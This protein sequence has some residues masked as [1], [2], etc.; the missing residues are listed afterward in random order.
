MTKALVLHESGPPENM[1]WEDV[2]VGDPGPG[3]VRLRH[4][5]IGFNSLDC[6]YRS[7]AIPLKTPPIIV[8]GEGAGIVEAVGEG[9]ETVAV[10]DRVAY[11]LARGAYAQERIIATEVLVPIP[12]G[13]TDRAAA[14]LTTKGLTVYQL[15]HRAHALKAG[16]TILFQAAAGGVGLIACQ[17]ARHIGAALI[18]AVGAEE[19]TA[20]VLDNGAAHAIVYTSDDVAERVREITGGRGCDAVFDAVGKDTIEASVKSLA[21][22]GTLVRYGDISGD[23]SSKLA[24]L[25]VSTYLF[26]MSI[27]TLLRQPGEYQ[28]AAAAVFDLA[29]S[30]ALDFSSPQTFA[31]KDAA[32][33]HRTLEA[34]RNIGPIVLLP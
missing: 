20:A 21:T 30:G 9:V 23:V 2:D 24:D 1:L 10:G 5:A 4:T 12:D 14:A 32:Q 33:A 29:A 25:P 26:K 17:W 3:E 19:K 16:Q 31:L 27:M 34:R 28:A 18:G 22:F 7:G 6:D 11:A 15:F 13:L 8:G